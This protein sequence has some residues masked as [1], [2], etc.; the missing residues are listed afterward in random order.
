[1]QLVSIELQA[2]KNVIFRSK[3]DGRF[4][5]TKGFSL[6]FSLL[7]AVVYFSLCQD[8]CGYFFFLRLLVVWIRRTGKTVSFRFSSHLKYKKA[9]KYQKEKARSWFF[10]LFSHSPCPCR[11]PFLYFFSFQH[12]Y[13]SR[14]NGKDSSIELYTKKIIIMIINAK[15]KWFI[16]YSITFS[17]ES[18]WPSHSSSF[19]TF[20]VSIF[21]FG[22]PRT[23]L[24]PLMSIYTV[25]THTGYKS[26]YRNCSWMWFAFTVGAAG[27]DGVIMIVMNSAPYL[28]LCIL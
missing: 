9:N 13:T 11:F 8:D 16:P 18:I 10:T 2:G 3:F 20:V 21:H 24:L 5:L 22:E 4:L 23:C 25:H 28:R 6:S 12:F 1:M 14:P 7:P 15:K 26:L 19:F 17:L 27:H